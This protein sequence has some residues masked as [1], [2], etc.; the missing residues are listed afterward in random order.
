MA[1]DA[2]TNRDSPNTPGDAASPAEAPRSA[3]GPAARHHFRA[4]DILERVSDAFIAL[5]REWRIVYANPEACR[6]NQKPLEEFQ[7]KIHWEEWPAAVGTD[8]ERQFRRAMD[9]QVDVHFEHRYAADP[10]DVWLEIDAYPTGQGLSLFYRDITTRKRAEEALKRSEQRYRSLIDATSQIVWTN[11]PEGEMRGPNLDWGAYTGQSEEGYQGYGWA[12]VVHPDDVQPTI[13]A[14][15]RAVAARSV[16]VFEHRLRRHDGVYHIFA[17]RA[18]PVLD[19]DGTI[20]EWV[21]VHT[22]VTE[23]KRVEDFSQQRTRLLALS[24]DVGRALTTHDTLADM[25]QGCAEAMVENLDAAFA[26]VWTLNTAGDV[27]ELKA[28]AG[29]YTHLDGPHGRV[30]MGQFKIGVIAQERR[31]HLTNA[32]VGDPRVSDQEWAA[33]E[34][35]IAFAGYPLVI[36][37]RL[38]GVVAMFARQPLSDVTLQTIGAVADEIAV[39][40]ERICTA[41]A[42]RE[43]NLHTEAILESI[44]DAFFALDEQWRFTYLNDQAERLLFRRREELLG[45]SLWDEFPDVVGSTF[46]QQYRRAATQQVVVDFEEFY[47]PLDTWFEV[48]AY[49]SLDGLSVYFHDINARKRA[50]DEREQLLAAQSARAEREAH[51]NR[52]GQAL[53]GSSVPEDVQGAAVSLLGEAL[54]ADRCYFAVYDL[55]RGLVTVARDWHRGGLP[56]IQGVYP[57]VNTVEMFRELYQNS[58]TSVIEDTATASLSAQTRANGES[59]GLRSRVSVALVDGEGVMA[60]L[61]AA[62]ADGPRAWTAEEVALIEAVATQ[63]RTAV[64]MARVTQREHNIATQLQEA[65]QPDLPGT[66][67]GLALTRHYRPALAEAGVGGD[68]YDVFAVEKGCTAIV[69]GDLS[70]KGLAAAAQVSTVRNMLRAF[71]YSLPTVAEAVTEL[72][73][74]LAENNL[75]TGFTTL[76]VGAYDSATGHLKYVNCGQEPALVRRAGTGAVEPLATTGPILGTIEG[77]RYVEADAALAPGDAVAIFTDGLT[78]VGA[79]RTDMLGVAGMAALLVEPLMGEEVQSAA[80]MAEALIRHLIAGVDA[81]AQTGARDDMCLLVGVM[82]NR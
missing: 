50:E 7:G 22:D 53:R 72:N 28:S 29:L 33:R 74:V 14:W 44:T 56:T 55:G 79:S 15:R 48:R 1:S 18:V 3:D 39:G 19:G 32:V 30:P 69:V 4:A 49:P 31:P 62:M 57:F 26:R 21:G 25:L 78:E 20:R 42:L 67:P 66:V 60:T 12:S 61:T 81:F 5:D 16:F 8:L 52:I 68:F 17:I 23:Q 34:G 6:I 37:D 58:D 82:D 77:I 38:V 76:F 59:L 70:G 41:E 75:L 13:D 73:R 43:A 64:E 27:L 63:M 2:H 40:V 65:L 71:L 10:Y 24:A 9:A 35:M 47:P 51:L 11:T 80:Q 46:D 45:R 54:G 36:E